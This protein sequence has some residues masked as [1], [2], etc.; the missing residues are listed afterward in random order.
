M[1]AE[2]SDPNAADLGAADPGG[3]DLVVTVDRGRCVGT[4]LCASTAPADL[5]LGEDGR[6]RPRRER[7]D[8]HEAVVEAAEL[9][10]ME[11]IAVHRAS[12]GELVAPDW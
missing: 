2:P 3:P 10:P 5:A 7:T 4:G 1:S 9:C 12:T 11:A 8:A 6:A